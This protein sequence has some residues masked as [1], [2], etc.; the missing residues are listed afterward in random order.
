RGQPPLYL[1][2]GEH[3]QQPGKHPRGVKNWREESTTDEASIRQWWGKWPEANIG[4]DTGKSGLLVL[5]A[6]QYKDGYAGD[7]L[8]S[9]RDEQ[10]PTV[11]TGGGGQH[12]WYRLPSD[13]QWGNSTG[14][15]PAGIDIRGAGGFVVA[16][17]SLHASGRT[18]E[19][20]LDYSLDDLP[21]ADVPPALA[22]IL[23]GAAKRCSFTTGRR[24]DGTT[25]TTAPDLDGLGVS[26][27]LRELITQA[28][29]RGQR[30]ETDMRLIV[31][32]LYAGVDDDTI[33]AIFEHNPIGTAGKFAERG[34]DYLARTLDKAHQYVD[35]HPTPEMARRI[36]EAVMFQLAEYDFA[37]LVPAELQPA[38]GYRSNETHRAV[39]QAALA[40]LHD[41][42][43]LEGTISINQ[44]M[45]RT[46]RGWDTCKRAML[47]LTWL[48]E[49]GNKDGAKQAITYR[50]AEPWRSCADRDRVHNR[51]GEILSRSAQLPWATHMGHDAFVRSLTNI[52]EEELDRRVENRYEERL[53]AIWDN[54]REIETGVPRPLRHVPPRIDLNRYK[55]RL[56]AL[57]PSAGPAVLLAIDA[58]TRHGAM[59]RKEL[60]E[61]LFKK[62]WSISRLV[63]RGLFLRLL[64]EG[65]DGVID[66]AEDWQAL[67]EALAP[68][69]P[70][71]GTA[72]KRKLAA[73][74]SRQS[75]CE[76]A[77]KNPMLPEEK[78]KALHRRMERAAKERLLL[79][80]D[81][82]PALACRKATISTMGRPSMPVPLTADIGIHTPD[83]N[84]AASRLQD[85]AYWHQI[86]SLTP[87]Q[88]AWVEEANRL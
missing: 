17:G 72:A 18:Y 20:E 12:L 85:A 30:S 74:N 6:D 37:D 33:R 52:T 27:A 68:V 39:A 3:C 23:D 1:A 38:N 54:K 86:G 40:I 4:I 67:A 25:T 47:C 42:G 49:P 60:G 21:I 11:L 44:L 50:L 36:L 5:D 62:K 53:S 79:A 87:A 56:E 26:A 7:S 84:S 81:E 78:R 51:G 2:E 31:G 15:L 73:L 45:E 71:A 9:E 66:L 76:A 75:Y 28:A 14:T 46:S 48:L 22:A 35:A 83:R 34:L 63:Q 70:T 57:I 65:D 32:L 24:W 41:Y 80:K 88:R 69:M 82:A 16:P 10:T 77:L 58:I 43:K 19:W 13:K 55:R 29:P 64:V 59:T 61:T 8:L